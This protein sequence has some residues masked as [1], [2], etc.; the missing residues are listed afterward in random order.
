[1][2]ELQGWLV[3]GSTIFGIIGI[4]SVVVRKFTTVELKVSELSRAIVEGFQRIDASHEE[5]KAT[6]NVHEQRLYRHGKAIAVLDARAE[7]EI[8]GE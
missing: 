7:R 8:N 4:I 2:T 1:M 6:L 3:I 5:M